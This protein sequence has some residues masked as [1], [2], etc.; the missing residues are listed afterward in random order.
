MPLAPC[1]CNPGIKVINFRG[2]QC[3]CF[4]ILFGLPGQFHFLNLLIGCCYLLLYAANQFSKSKWTIKYTKEAKGHRLYYA[5]G[6]KFLF[7]F[8]SASFNGGFPFLALSRSVFNSF[9]VPCEQ[10]MSQLRLHKHNKQHEGMTERWDGIGKV[11]KMQR[12]T[13]C[14]R[15]SWLGELHATIIN[16]CIHR[17]ENS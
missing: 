16:S 17:R 1:N 13:V 6:V 7:C 10:N 2:A 4:Q 8:P 15:K 12:A 14:W 9:S 5:S 11:S 3:H